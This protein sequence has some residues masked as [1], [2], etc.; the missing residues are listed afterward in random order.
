M[1]SQDTSN[2]SQIERSGARIGRTN[3]EAEAAVTNADKLLV[4]GTQRATA[5][6]IIRPPP[7]TCY[8]HLILRKADA[9]E[10]PLQRARALPWLFALRL[11]P[12]EREVL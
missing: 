4:G 9:C 3:P 1:F 12:F 11:L 5:V 7:S 10:W 2:P 6:A 8:Q